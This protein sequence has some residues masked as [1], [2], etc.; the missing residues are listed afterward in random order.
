MVTKV[1]MA[2]FFMIFETFAI[3]KAQLG[4]RNNKGVKNLRTKGA[5]RLRHK[6]KK[7]TQKTNH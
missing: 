2:L 1:L 6:T 5:K 4:K 7:H 3:K